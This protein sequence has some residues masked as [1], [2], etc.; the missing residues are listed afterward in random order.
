MY[1]INISIKVDK[2]PKDQETTMFVQH[3]AWFSENFQKGTFLLLGPYQDKD[4]TGV[5]IAQV[6]NREELEKILLED[7]YYPLGLA[8]YEVNEFK[9]AMVAGNIVNFKNQ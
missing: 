1:I 2:V 4:N 9:L 3:R 7:V 8:N 5:I 6:K